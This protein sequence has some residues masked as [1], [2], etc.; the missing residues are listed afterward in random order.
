MTHLPKINVSE[1]ALQ[2]QRERNVEKYKNDLEVADGYRKMAK[3]LVPL[4]QQNSLVRFLVKWTMTHPIAKVAEVRKID[5]HHPA[6]YPIG[7]FWEAVWR[8][9]GLSGTDKFSL[10]YVIKRL[11]RFHRI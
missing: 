4:M 3:W 1:E 9:Y 10:S 5:K 6:L 11:A 8:V 7:L 2:K